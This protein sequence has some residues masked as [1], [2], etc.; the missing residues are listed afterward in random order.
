[1]VWQKLCSWLRRRPR[2]DIHVVLYH[3][4]GCH[5]C[6]DALVLLRREQL[7]RPFTLEV[8]DVDTDAGL[9]AA[10]GAQVP[11]VTVNGR[12]RFRGRV[13]AAL[14]RRLVG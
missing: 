5:L 2:E 4:E 14:L 6:E 8:I 1:M 13:N 3:R 7:R 12:V 10:Y 9:A 11:V